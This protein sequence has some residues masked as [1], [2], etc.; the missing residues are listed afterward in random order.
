M[1]GDSSQ[2]VG[3][4]TGTYTAEEIKS[5]IGC[6][7]LVIGSRFHSLVAGLSQ[8]VPVVA[9]GWSHKYEKLLRSFELGEYVVPFEDA[10]LSYVI[11]KV[12]SAWEMRDSN[13]SLVA[14]K[15]TDVKQKVD[16]TFNKV[17]SFLKG[18]IKKEH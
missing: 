8:G 4:M 11:S 5:V 18:Y 10:E 16:E 15:L 6:S 1:L 14:S 13:T 3:L 17:D 2:R 7:D 12:K 9:I